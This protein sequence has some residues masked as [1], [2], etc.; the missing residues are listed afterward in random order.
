MRLALGQP[1][2]VRIDE[3]PVGARV[4]DEKRAVG[5][6]NLRVMPRDVLVRQNPVIIGQPANGAPARKGLTGLAAHARG[7][8]TDDFQ[9]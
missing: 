4:L 2:L 6:E 7:L 9:G 5:E 1:I 3:D 8:L